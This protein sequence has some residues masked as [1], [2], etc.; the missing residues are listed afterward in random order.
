MAKI[1]TPIPP[2]SM[3]TYKNGIVHPKLWLWDSWTYLEGNCIHLYALALSR[4][5]E[6]GTAILPEHRNDYPFHFRHFESSNEGISW[7]DLGP[8]L[9]PSKDPKSFYSRNV[10]SGSATRLPDNR[11]LMGFTGLREVD[12]DHP[13]LQSIG[14]ATSVDG[15]AFDQ[16]AKEPASCPRRDYDAIIAA[17]YYLGPKDQ[18]GHKDGE[19]GGPIMAWRD[20]YTLIDNAGTIH[21]FWSAK[22]SPKTGA[23]AHATLIETNRGFEIETLHPPIILPDGKSITQA[24]VPKI[25]YDVTSES[26]YLC[27]RH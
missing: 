16:I 10:W 4:S 12:A 8:V 7:T 21:A 1:N 26:Y 3:S 24:E 27:Q 14:F 2:F 13:F 25:Y 17:G 22:V 6:D 5:A 23:I 15:M 19:D 11:K 9:T 20:P 18:L